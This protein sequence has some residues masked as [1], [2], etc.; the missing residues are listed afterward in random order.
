M[1]AF[2]LKSLIEVGGD[3]LIANLRVRRREERVSASRNSNGDGYRACW[4][5]RGSQRNSSG[6]P[7][8]VTTVGRHRYDNLHGTIVA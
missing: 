3:L 6:Q 1:K 7:C 8:T 4:R 5:V 2:R